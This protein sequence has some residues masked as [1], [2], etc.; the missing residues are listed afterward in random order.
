MSK[1]RYCPR[2]YE[3]SFWDDGFCCG[4]CRAF[5]KKNNI[6]GKI[7]SGCLYVILILVVV[8]WLVDT[9]SPS[10][11]TDTEGSKASIE[12]VEHKTTRKKK[13]RKKSIEITNEQT[14]LESEASAES[15]EV[16]EETVTLDDE[17][18][19]AP[20]S[21]PKEDLDNSEQTMEYIPTE[22]LGLQDK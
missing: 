2:E 10:T 7:P 8:V 20:L 14:K 4:R 9:C 17:V 5:A 21:V 6:Q 3:S 15:S 18:Q 16:I 11:K 19:E 12:N 13:K 1:C 22:D